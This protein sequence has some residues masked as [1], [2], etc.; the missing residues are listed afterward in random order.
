MMTQKILLAGVVLV[1]AGL[2]LGATSARLGA[3]PPPD[4]EKGK[5]AYDQCAACH[6]IDGGESDGPTLKGVFGR[7]AASLE[8]FRYSAAMK[9]SDIVWNAETLDRFLADPQDT[10]PGNK[11]AFSGI[12]VQAD[13]DDL[14]AYIQSATKPKD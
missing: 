12:L 11:M 13:R 5:A 10:V 7:K 6:T 4:V 14:I 3:A 2:T 1:T 9:R 8:A